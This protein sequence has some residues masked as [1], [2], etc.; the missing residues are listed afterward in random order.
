MSREVYRLSFKIFGLRMGKREVE[1]KKSAESP[2][3]PLAKGKRLI[4]DP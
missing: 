4:N 1:V 2:P 3:L